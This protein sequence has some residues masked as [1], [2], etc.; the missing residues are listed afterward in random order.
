[1][2]DTRRNFLQTATA[3]A[4]GLS[5]AGSVAAQVPPA[6]TPAQGAG[7][8]QGRGGRGQRQPAGPPQPASEVQVPKMKFGGVEIS[9]MVLGVNPFYG[10]AHFNNTYGAIMKEWYTE[11]RVLGV[12]HQCNRFGIN[13]FNYVHLDRGPQ[14]WER[15]EAEGGK[16]HLIVQVTAGVDI[17]ALVKTM[18]PL[19]LQRQG[20]VVD[21]AYQNGEMDTVKEWCKQARDLGVQVGVGSHIP[22]VIAKVEEENWDVDFYSGCVYNRR[23]TTEEWRKVLGGELVEMQGD[24][25]LQND[26]PRMY[27][28]LRQTKKPCFAFKI[29]AAGRLSDRAV[30]QAF[31]TA[32]D[33]IKPIDGVYVGMF[34]KMKDE[35]RENA[36]RVH[37]ILTPGV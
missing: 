15:F 18:K 26:P 9:R 20:E 4:A 5:G 36:E 13:A 7:Q 31:R 32:F 22:E 30:D 12:M 28:V 21:T 25:Y 37:R 35:V 19:A 10:F 23:R 33:S 24:C 6:Q 29:L 11:E 8:G 16:M 27:K 17:Q 14:D 1:M 34:P 3:M 2:S